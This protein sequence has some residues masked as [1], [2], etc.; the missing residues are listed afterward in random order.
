MVIGDIKKCFDSIDHVKLMEI[1]N[2][3]VKD[4]QFTKVIWKSLRAGIK[5][6][7][8]VVKSKIGTPQGSIISPI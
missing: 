7:G 2:L 3:K 8:K 6:G 5:I 1:I 4:E